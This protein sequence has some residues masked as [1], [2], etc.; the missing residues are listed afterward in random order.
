M[1]SEQLFNII[2]WVYILNYTF[3]FI[4]DVLNL[5]HNKKPVSILLKGIFTKEKEVKSQQYFAESSKF[6]LITGLFSFVIILFLLN[7]TY[8]AV[9]SQYF[10]QYS[11]NPIYLALMF[12]G[13][14]FLFRIY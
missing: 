3:N 10:E 8:F 2:I 9:I 4:L 13:G 7:D 14:L 5:S 1:N 12:F 11:T 6:S